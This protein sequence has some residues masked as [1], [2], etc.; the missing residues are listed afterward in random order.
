MD[1]NFLA[2]CRFTELD[3]INRDECAAEWM[4]CKAI[5]SCCELS[6]CYSLCEGSYKVEAN[7][8]YYYYYIYGWKL[9]HILKR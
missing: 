5:L 2:E 9:L 3:E 1:V 4:A 7:I 8:T 6:T